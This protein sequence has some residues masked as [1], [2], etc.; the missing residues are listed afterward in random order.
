MPCALCEGVLTEVTAPQPADAQFCFQ[1]LRRSLGPL[2][3]PRL[4]GLES[5][6]SVLDSHLSAGLW[7]ASSHS[8]IRLALDML[9]KLFLP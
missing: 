3:L 4:A 8:A 1:D 2:Q 6:L 7:P 9:P 5:Y